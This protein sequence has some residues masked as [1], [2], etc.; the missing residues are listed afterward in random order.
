MELLSQ[1]K[2]KVLTKVNLFHLK[3]D[4][5]EFSSAYIKK[6]NNKVIKPSLEQDHWRGQGQKIAR[7]VLNQPVLVADKQQPHGY[8]SSALLVTL[9]P[10]NYHPLLSRETEAQNEGLLLT[11]ETAAL[12]SCCSGRSKREAQILHP[13]GSG[14]PLHMFT[15]THSLNP[16]KKQPCC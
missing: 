11:E 15:D 14:L 7:T 3:T 9:R 2:L 12:S 16:A 4:T 1:H 10:R 13:S 8:D 6:I 5:R